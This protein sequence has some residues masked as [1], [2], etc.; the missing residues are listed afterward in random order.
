[1]PDLSAVAHSAPPYWPAGLESII[2]TV[3]DGPVVLVPHSNAGLFVPAVI[4][5]LGDQVRGVVFVDAALPGVGHHSKSD[6]LRRLA[7]VDGLLPPWTSWWD[8]ADVVDLFPNAS[9]RAEVEAEQPRIPLAYY[10]HLP[11]APDGW[12]LPPCGYIWFGAP[13]DKGAE[14]TAQCGWPTAHLPGGHLHMLVDPDA[15]AT[16]VLKMAGAWR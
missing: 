6:F 8:E 5:A 4:K 11:P 15:V 10:D 2:R 16:A 3:A 12:A 14:Q 13:Y 7:T 9:V 1:M